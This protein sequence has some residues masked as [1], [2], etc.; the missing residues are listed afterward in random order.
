MAST[1]GQDNPFRYRGYYYDTETGFYY[2]NARYYNPEWGRFIS[3]DPV[4]DASSAVGCNLFAYCG[5]DPVNR[6]DHS[7]AFWYLDLLSALVDSLIPTP[8]ASR[9]VNMALDAL[10]ETTT[11]NKL[12]ENQKDPVG[13]MFKYGFFDVSYNGCEG[14][15]VHNA[16][17][18]IGK[19]S[20][21]SKA[22]Y[23][24]ESCGAMWMGGL[25]GSNLKKIGKVLSK[26]NV[27]YSDVELNE[28]NK[29]GVYIISYWTTGSGFLGITP[30]HTVAVKYDGTT[31]FTYNKGGISTQNPSS[32]ARDYIC[33]YYLGGY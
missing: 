20:S 1:L 15:A 18:L 27:Q 12:I 2:L 10:D 8:I 30:L 7:G 6:S 22:L 19:D 5:N 29:P 21:L 28:I 13:D 26:N 31:Y 32:Y 24:M 4:L 23:D 3:A 16:L 11:K 14:I 33:G 9:I 25:F 17:V